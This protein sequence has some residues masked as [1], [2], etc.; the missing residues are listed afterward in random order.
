MPEVMPEIMLAAQSPLQS[1]SAFTARDISIREEAGFTLTQVAGFGRAFEKPLAAAVGKLPA[2]PGALQVN[3]AFT[4][5]RTG[6]QQFW[7]VGDAAPQGLPGEC[8]VTPLTSSRCRIRVEGALARRVLAR[9]AAI[10]FDP[11]SFK[12]GHFAMTGIHHTP[13]LVHCVGDNAFHIYAM[14]TFA[15]AVWEWLV[16]AGEGMVA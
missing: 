4:V 13:V 2:K 11:R 6:P 15:L 5:F 1:V 16:D 8:L 10:D 9:A 12:P 3:D 7:C 14:R